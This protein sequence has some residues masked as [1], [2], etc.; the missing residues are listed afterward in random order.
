MSLN[1]GRFSL[2]FGKKQVPFHGLTT[3]DRNHAVTKNTA[4]KS[5]T[6]NLLYTTREFVGIVRKSQSMISIGERDCQY[7][8][9]S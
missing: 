6:L 3:N 9:F 1:I 4:R 2:I 8:T 7:P 5:D